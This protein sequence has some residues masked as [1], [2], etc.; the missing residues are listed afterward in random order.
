[1]L[2]RIFDITAS[3]VGLVLVAPILLP[4]IFLV[5]WHDK[6]SPFYIADRVGRD[7]RSFRMVKLRSMVIN[8]DKSGVDSTGAN[9][10]RITAVGG[11]IR[12]YKFDE[13]TQLWNVLNGDMS[14]VGPR[15]NVK[16]ETDLYT[17]VERGLLEV[18]PGITDIASIVFSDEGDIL[19]DQADPDI[20]YN[21]LIRPGKS[22][23]GLIYIKNQSILLDIR[24]CLLTVIAIFSRNKALIGV[25]KILQGVH[26]P[27]DIVQ[28]A[29]RR[30]P[31][32]PRPPP[33]SVRIV[34]SRDGN[35]A[36]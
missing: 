3:G 25:Q 12:R 29:L 18:K 36:I 20:A 14:L 28:M 2:K 31:L 19:K 27:D 21:Q 7:D 34:T 8:A 30:Q 9:D 1:M 22:I 15:P 24:L 4:V 32:V 5:W 16:R 10:A 26:A 23:L 6:H 35:P 13:L 17:P 11:F 33:G